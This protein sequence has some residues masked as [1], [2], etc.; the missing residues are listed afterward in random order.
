MNTPTAK[1]PRRGRPARSPQQAEASRERIIDAARTLFAAEGYDGVSMRKIAAMAECS[2]AALY[3]L[4]PN[5]RQLLRHIWESVFTD[6]IA[7]LERAHAQHDGAQRLSAICRAFIDFWL[8]RPDD[9][10]A[11]FLIEDR[12]QDQDDRYFVESAN[13][14]PRLTLIRDCIREAQARG[15]LRKADPDL[16]QSLL[17]CGVQGVVLNLIT[18]PEYPWGDPDTLKREMVQAL[19]VGLR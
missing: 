4:F 3:T 12:L 10:R 1:R 2:P 13:V 17:L 11:I 6:L 7:E 9:Y 8:A 18:I 14:L 16:I 19:L 15:E 5:K